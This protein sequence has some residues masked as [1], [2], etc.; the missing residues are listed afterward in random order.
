MRI[1]LG[2]LGETPAFCYS[3]TKVFGES[4][5]DQGETVKLNHIFKNLFILFPQLVVKTVLEIL[6]SCV[7]L[8]LLLLIKYFRISG[9]L[10]SL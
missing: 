3:V 8:S 9:Y 6:A 2:K 5:Q 1:N 4:N 7:F 10:K